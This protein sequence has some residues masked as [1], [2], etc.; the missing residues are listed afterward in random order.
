MLG[1]NLLKNSAKN[2]NVNVLSLRALSFELIQEKG[3][4][5]ARW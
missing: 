3:A 2:S 5:P 4:S 1:M